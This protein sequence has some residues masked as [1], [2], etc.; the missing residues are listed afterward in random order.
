MTRGGGRPTVARATR[1]PVGTDHLDGHPNPLR[2]RRLADLI[3]REL[4]LHCNT[5]V[6]KPTV[7]DEFDTKTVA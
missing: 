4:S 1:L 7:I 6:M 2:A 5:P 3:V